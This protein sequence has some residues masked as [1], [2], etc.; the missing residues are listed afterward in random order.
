VCGGGAGVWS[1]YYWFGGQENGPLLDE[2]S[3]KYFGVHLRTGDYS[4]S[5]APFNQEDVEWRYVADKDEETGAY[6]LSNRTCGDI[7][8]RIT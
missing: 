5:D 7:I 8:I 3:G 6:T 1:G 2:L 4:F